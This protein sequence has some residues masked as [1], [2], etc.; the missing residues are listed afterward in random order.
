MRID[1]LSIFPEM[2]AGP[3]AASLLG[4]AQ[5]DGRLEVV[6]TNIRDFASDKHCSVDDSPYGGGAGMVMKCEP[7]FAAVE[8]LRTQNSLK[9][10]ILMSPRGERLTQKKVRELAEAPDLVVLCARYEGVDE[11]ISDSLVTEEI[12]IGDYVLSGGEVPALVLVEAISRMIPGVIGDWES[13]ETDSFYADC[14]G[15]PQYTRPPV[16]RDMAVP[17][18]LREGN[19][20][21][22]RRWR[23]KEALRVTLRRRPDLLVELDSEEKKLLAEI[24]HETP[25][26]ERE[27]RDE[28]RR[29]N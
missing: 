4:K 23:K 20:A 27:N 15:P 25:I 14:L 18:V 5:A 22:I 2:L 8:S 3:L 19:H 29:P 1:I 7:I 12:S 28:P 9:R 11:R 26:S 16:F 17:D 6:L 24:E 13:V 10:V 21:A